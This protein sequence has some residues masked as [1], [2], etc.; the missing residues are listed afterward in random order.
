MAERATLT[1]L[2]LSSYGFFVSVWAQVKD[3]L[4][5]KADED[6]SLNRRRSDYF[7]VIR[8]ADLF[9]IRLVYFCAIFYIVFSSSIYLEWGAIYDVLYWMLLIKILFLTYAYARLYNSFREISLISITI[10]LLDISLF[11]VCTF[12][13]TKPI[14]SEEDFVDPFFE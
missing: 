6:F 13:Y 1:V 12:Y 14:H 5:T 4:A 3:I 10:L 9:G 8:K 11:I 7:C 2:G